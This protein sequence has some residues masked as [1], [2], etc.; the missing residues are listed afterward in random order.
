MTHPEPFANKILDQ[1]QRTAAKA[2]RRSFWMQLKDVPIASKLSW[3]TFFLLIIGV[4]IWLCYESTQLPDCHLRDLRAVAHWFDP[5]FFQYTLLLGL[6]A[7]LIVPIVPLIYATSM[8]QRKI[9]R[10]RDELPDAEWIRVS[11]RLHERNSSLF[12]LNSAALT[13]IMVTLGVAILLLFKPVRD[14]GCGVDFSRGANML[15]LGP[16]M[17]MPHQNNAYSD[18][19][20]GHLV[21]SLVGFQFGFLGAYI[22]F[23]TSLSRAYFTLDLTPETFVEGSLRIAIAS[24]L[25]LILSFCME[26]VSSSMGGGSANAGWWLPA[27]SFFFG[28]FPKRALAFLENIAGAYLRRLATALG[29]ADDDRTIA[30]QVM[31][32]SNLHGM[33]FSHELRLEREGFDGVEN[34]SHAN[35]ADLAV[36]TGFS[37]GQLRH[38]R[39]AAWLAAHLREDYNRFVCLT[40]IMSREELARFVTATSDPQQV[41]CL[42]L[43]TEVDQKA[44]QL[45]NK[46]AIILKLPDQ[47]AIRAA[48]P[49]PDLLLD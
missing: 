16:Y 47:D 10:L 37:Y 44:E 43:G 25:S 38:W 12:Y 13:T 27:V 21:Q 26:P 4:V 5:I 49:S 9:N 39:S 32:L 40:G 1:R 33:S 29:A 24:V 45:R 48:T 34:L 14:A 28:F 35:A 46:V 22:Y 15:L 8:S 7:I 31:P 42:L 17:E 18:A 36:R 2:E 19:F 3:T 6:I 20:L 23:L 41:L 30:N 11:P